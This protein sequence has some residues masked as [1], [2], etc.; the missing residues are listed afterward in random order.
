MLY[1]NALLASA[2][3]EAYQVTG[4]QDFAQVVRAILRYVERD[5][6]S[7]DGAFYSATDADSPGPSGERQEGWFFTW[8]P[9][10]LDAVL[11][12]DRAGAVG[13]FYGVTESGNF[14][15]RTI[16]ST[17]R[18]LADVAAALG[19]YAD[20]LRRTVDEARELLYAARA[21][22]PPPPLR[23]EK[24]LTAWNGLMYLGVR[25]GGLSHE[26]ACVRGAC[27]AGRR[28]MCS[29]T[30]GGMAGCYAPL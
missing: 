2:F 13:A 25:T 23:D 21:E 12:G 4:R 15:G 9:D 17:P 14:E 27:D 28:T 19:M 8:T 10:E 20:T 11:G 3:L 5:M 29:R 30:C 18:P 26:R 16:L 22:R 1:D 6:T 7:P 24:I